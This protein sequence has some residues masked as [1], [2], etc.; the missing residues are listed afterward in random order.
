MVSCKKWRIR[1]YQ[2]WCSWLWN[3]YREYQ[4]KRCRERKLSTSI[5]QQR[6]LLALHIRL[7]LFQI[8]GSNNTKR[9]ERLCHSRLV[10]FL[11]TNRARWKRISPYPKVTRSSDF[12]SGQI[13]QTAMEKTPE[14]KK[15]GIA[16][17]NILEIQQSYLRWYN[18]CYIACIQKTRAKLFKEWGF[19]MNP[20]DPC[21]WNKIVGKHQM[22]TMFPTDD[23]LMVHP[24]SYIV[25][26]D[27]NDLEQAY[28]KR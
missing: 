15:M 19:V 23:L 14:T 7:L 26:L 22:T 6:Q 21:V 13:R 27:I 5:H 4:D 20:Y 18:E 11:L 2:Y 1:P 3:I 28:V 8:Y 25:T 17:G 24:K 10:G 9:K 16:V 12:T